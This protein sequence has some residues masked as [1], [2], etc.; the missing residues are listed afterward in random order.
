MYENGAK[1]KTAFISNMMG[2]IAIF[3]CPDLAKRISR[4]QIAISCKNKKELPNYAYPIHVLTVSKVAKTVSRGIE[5][6]IYDSDVQHISQLSSQVKLKKTIFG[7][8]YLISE[9]A[10]QERA[11]QK[12]IIVFELSEEEMNIVKKLGTE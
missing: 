9:R 6:I 10:A 11:A 4:A 12:D 3:G 2:D 8:G 7:S 5:T 1:V